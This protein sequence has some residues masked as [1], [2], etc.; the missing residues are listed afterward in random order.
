MKLYSEL[1][2]ITNS[3]IHLVLATRLTASSLSVLTT[4]TNTPVVTN[5]SV[6]TN[7]LQS[8]EVITK[9]DIEV[10]GELLRVLA[11][12]DVLLPVKEPVWDSVLTWVLHD[13]D[14]LLDFIFS[15]FTGSLVQVDFSHLAAQVGVPPTDT[16]NGSEGK[17]DL[18]LTLKVRVHNTKN[19][20]ERLRHNHRHL[21]FLFFTGRGGRGNW[22]VRCARVQ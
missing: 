1:F 8:L 22:L 7:L 12:L 13:G 3:I 16:L 19:V 21:F 2:A 14:E 18:P 15:Q 17:H 5:T 11:V 10:V 4:D 9:L 6:G 20:L